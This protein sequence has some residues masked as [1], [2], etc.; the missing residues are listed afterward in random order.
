MAK[1]MFG[2]RGVRPTM[3]RLR[4]HQ[5]T[6]DGAIVQA[7]VGDLII[8]VSGSKPITDANWTEYIQMCRDISQPRPFKGVLNYSPVVSPT[9]KQRSVFMTELNSYLNLMSHTALISDSALVRGALTA[10]SWVNRDAKMT[11]KPFSPRE[12]DDA[13]SWLGRAITFHPQDAKNL[14]LE[15]ITAQGDDPM[16]LVDFARAKAG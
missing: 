16:R 12:V 15:L 3:Y 10:M 2:G 14:L 7:G 11:F 1:L 5:R 4:T 9:A 6:T 13:L 8:F